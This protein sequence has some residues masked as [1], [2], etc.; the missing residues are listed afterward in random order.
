MNTRARTWRV[1]DYTIPHGPAS[2]AAAALPA[3]ACV[4]VKT[5]DCDRLAQ[6]T[7]APERQPG[8]RLQLP[9]LTL[10]LLQARGSVALIPPHRSRRRWWVARQPSQRPDRTHV[11]SSRARPTVQVE[12]PIVVHETDRKAD[13]KAPEL[14]GSADQAAGTGGSRR[15]RPRDG[16]T[17]IGSR[18][19]GRDQPHQL[20]WSSAAVMQQLAL[21]DRPLR[22]RGS[23]LPGPLR[24]PRAQRPSE[25]LTRV[26]ASGPGELR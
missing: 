19:H 24:V 23:G 25:S 17:H 7:P 13:R 9:V 15:R 20:C 5:L 22:R 4:A 26:H 2:I 14:T 6:A 1:A 18:H 3:G 21:R 11:E 12:H 16:G 8:D 10:E